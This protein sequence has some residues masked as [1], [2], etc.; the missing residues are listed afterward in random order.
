MQYIVIEMLLL[1]TYQSGSLGIAFLH[2]SLPSPVVPCIGT[3]I[4]TA[5]YHNAWVMTQTAHIVDGF[6]AHTLQPFTLSRIGTA[7]KHEVLP[8]HQSHL[9]AEVIEQVILI[10]A[11]T[12]HAN[13]VHIG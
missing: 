11:T 2:L 6:L 8:H 1:F 13:H 12:P 5:P 3:L 9:V 7:G 10:D 4:P